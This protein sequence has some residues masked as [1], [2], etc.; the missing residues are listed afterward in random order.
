MNSISRKNG[1]PLNRWHI[2]SQHQYEAIP[3][4][5]L[6]HLTFNYDC[7]CTFR[8]QSGAPCTFNKSSEFITERPNVVRQTFHFRTNPGCASIAI[9]LKSPIFNRKHKNPI[10]YGSIDC[11]W[12]WRRRSPSRSQINLHNS[13][14]EDCLPRLE[15]FAE[16][17]YIS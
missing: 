8:L 16:I 5:C 17:F 13:P 7:I 1:T 12:R 10:N 2:I 14:C 4:Q 11:R 15:H 9:I 3:L 6:G